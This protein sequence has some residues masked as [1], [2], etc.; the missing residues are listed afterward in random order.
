M[1][2]PNPDILNLVDSQPESELIRTY[3]SLTDADDLENASK[4]RAHAGYNRL[5]L[6]YLLY[7]A[8][9]TEFQPFSTMHFEMLNAL[10]RG[11]QGELTNI[12]A[13]RGASKSTLMSIAMPLWKVVYKEWDELLNVTPDR[14]ILIVSFKH[15]T[16][17]DRIQD[18]KTHIESNPKILADFGDLRG[19]RGERWGVTRLQTRNGVTLSP[20]SRTGAI[21]GALTKSG[22]PSLVIADDLDDA[23]H[24]LNEEWRQKTMD[25]VNT[26][27]IRLGKL[28]GSTNFLF[29]DT[30]KHAQGISASLKNTP[31]WKTLEYRAITEPATLYH[32]D[33]HI[34]ELWQEWEEYY[35]DM[36]VDDAE[37]E[38]KAR[39]F[40]RQHETELRRGVVETWKEQITYLDVR[41][42]ICKTG[43]F[44]TMRELQNIAVPTEA[45]TFDM[46]NAVRFNVTEDG[47]LCSDGKLAGWRDITG[48]TVFLDD[49][50]GKDAE[51]R[52]FACAVAVAWE[53]MPGGRQFVQHNPDSLAGLHGYVI[54][55][56]LDR[57]PPSAQI[58]AML[59][60]YERTQAVLAPAQPRFILA[61]EERGRESAQYIRGHINQIF[62]DE[63]D[64]RN[65]IT[66]SAIRWHLP[67]TNKD[68]RI[69]AIESA[70]KNGWVSFNTR[71]DPESACDETDFRVH[72]LMG[73]GWTIPRT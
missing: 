61:I 10:P 67:R 16:A 63:C 22:R 30:M 3:K 64:R 59:D 37:R 8:D 1:I 33:E 65:Y 56:W 71:L 35:T 41:K 51:G 20:H 53:R 43:Y 28:D 55:A 44:A 45:S 49:A 25:W 13:P 31:D 68:W 60:V 9:P 69:S 72:R 39:D 26:A 4:L 62:K 46:D 73:H 27:L 6:F 14:H 58:T 70:V 52:S 29:I 11:A 7:L 19:G 32:P 54:E 23:E 57:V 17:Q 40:Y 36:S 15:T 2:L 5:S 24:A 21:R 42:E 38:S 48:F 50:G 34:E 66:P 47:L 12:L 18:I